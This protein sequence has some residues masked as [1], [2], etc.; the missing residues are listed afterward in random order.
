MPRFLIEVSYCGTK[1]SGFQKQHNADTIQSE[2]EKALKTF[3]R[4]ELSLTGSSRTDAGVHALQNFF[5]TDIPTLIDISQRAVYGLNAILPP[6]IAIAGLRE[7]PA[8]FHCRFHA[9]SRSYLYQIYA[10]KDPF[11]VKRAFFYP[12]PL[13]LKIMNEA[14]SIILHTSDFTSFSK[15]NTQV[16]N[17]FCNIFSS[18]WT[19]NNVLEFRVEGNRFLRGMVRGLVGTMLRAGVGK[20]NLEEFKKIIEDKD[21]ARVNFAVPAHGLYLTKVSL[22]FAQ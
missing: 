12:Y 8:D 7:V 14:A 15:R 3:Y 17:F 22:P 10:S 18:R 1:Y 6:D 9:T 20:I 11:L 19:M 13:D 21:C 16:N 4:E 2:L 5:H